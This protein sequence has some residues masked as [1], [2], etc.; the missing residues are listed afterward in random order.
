[1][2]Q[3]PFLLIM[4]FAALVAQA[5]HKVLQFPFLEKP[6]EAF[7]D[8]LV[9][10]DAFK[11]DKPWSSELNCKS[12]LVTPSAA[13]Y[14]YGKFEFGSVVIFPDD[15]GI[16]RS[17]SHFKSFFKG[18]AGDQA[19]D[20]MAVLAEYFNSL[21]EMK[22]DR[23]KVK[24]AYSDEKIITWKKER[25]KITLKLSSIKKRKKGQLFAILDLYIEQEK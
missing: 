19:E 11:L 17:F 9:C 5:Q 13:V 23:S 12:Y 3:L 21:L 25:I 18:A 20:D 14:K 10:K 8:S 22:G 24:N 2:K 15:A 16:I 7:K 6:A 1:M 4:C